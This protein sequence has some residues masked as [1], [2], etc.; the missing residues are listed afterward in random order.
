MNATV[1]QAFTVLKMV[2]SSMNSLDEICLPGELVG[3]I[4]IASRFWLYK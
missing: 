4:C 3:D 1:H 2:D